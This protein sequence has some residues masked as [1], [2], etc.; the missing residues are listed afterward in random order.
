MFRRSLTLTGLSA[1]L[2]A[3]PALAQQGPPGGTPYSSVPSVPIQRCANL[4]NTFE[5]P[6][7]MP[8]GGVMPMKADL[9][10]I[11]AQGFDTVRF[12][13]R[14]SAYAKDKAPYTIDL[15]FFA[16]V[17]QVVG[18][19]TDAGLNIIVDLHHFEEIYAKPAAHR[20][21]LVALWGQIAEHYKDQPPSVLFEVLNEPND[22]LDNATLEPMLVDVLATIR[23]TNPTRKVIMGGQFWS[24]ISSLA[25]FDPP[26]DPNVIA[27]FHFYEPF[28]FTHQ[29]AS[30]VKDPPPAPRVFGLPGDEEWMETMQKEVLAFEERTG[31]PLF[32]GEFGAI[33]SANLAE[34]ARY[35]D[36]VRRTAEGL[37]VPWCVWSYDNTF[38]IHRDGQWIP[39]MLKA[40]GL[41]PESTAPT[42]APTTGASAP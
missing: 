21:E 40:L 32:L 19:A 2:I 23:R 25:S 14:W 9:A 29:G 28:A 30:W 42:T 22:K 41:P 38:H 6:A 7:G 13:I 10:D 15:A 5:Q 11:K 18:W 36:T 39:V 1:A 33:D 3:Q 24:G 12:P 16:K 34:R 31:V 27:T 4:G 20:A 8:W 26:K 37:G 17:D 35:T